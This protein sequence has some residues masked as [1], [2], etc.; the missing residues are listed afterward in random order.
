[1][2][3][4]STLICPACAVLSSALSSSIALSINAV[5]STLCYQIKKESQGGH[6]M[7]SFSPG[8]WA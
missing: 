7:T 2:L 3:H 1:M 4:S 8:P 6:V 5:R